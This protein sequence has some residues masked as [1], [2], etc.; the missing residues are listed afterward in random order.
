[1]F[2]LGKWLAKL[3]YTHSSYKELRNFVLDAEA[4]T[5]YIKTRTLHTS[6]ENEESEIINESY[7]R[8]ILEEHTKRAIE[9]ALDHYSRQMIVTTATYCEAIL[10][11]FFNNFFTYNQESMH[12]YINDESAK[13]GRGY[14][15][16]SEVLSKDNIEEIKRELVV[17]ATKNAVGGSLETISIRIHKLTKQQVAKDLVKGIQGMLNV[18]NS[19]VHEDDEL[20]ITAKNVEKAFS[21]AEDLLKVLGKIS[22]KINLPYYDPAYIIDKRPGEV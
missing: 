13:I 2:E 20:E 19:I 14:I 12:D 11:E 9:D 6:K 7:I 22:K 1:M 21:L 3:L 5:E 15:K 17:R 16:I 18:R 4:F 10:S 8:K